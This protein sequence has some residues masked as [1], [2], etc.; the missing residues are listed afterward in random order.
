[1]KWYI[2]AGIAAVALFPLGAI[3]AA[4]PAIIP[5]PV[6][7]QTRPGIFT[8]CPSQPV[9]GASIRA[10]RKIVADSPSLQTA[11]YL[12]TMLFRS[13]GCRF[14]IVTNNTPGPV[15]NALLLTTANA[16]SLGAEGYELTVSPDSVV[17]RAPGQGGIFYG[18]QSLLQLFP[19]QIMSPQA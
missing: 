9:P 18:V 6:T 16:L 4:A 17:I 15:R 19:P 11:Q 1:M 5:L 14:T 3:A 10:T 2:V 7:L 13:T 8:L 12:A